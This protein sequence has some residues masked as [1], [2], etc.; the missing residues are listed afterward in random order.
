MGRTLPFSGQDGF[1]AV[2]KDYRRFALPSPRAL[3]W[4]PASHFPRCASFN[5]HP[6]SPGGLEPARTD[7]GL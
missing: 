1:P 5:Q 2:A 3:S 7:L 4:A 6:P